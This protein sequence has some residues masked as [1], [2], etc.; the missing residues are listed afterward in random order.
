MPVALTCRVRG[1]I[2]AVVE[3]T[4]AFSV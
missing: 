1:V 3:P 2:E 4:V